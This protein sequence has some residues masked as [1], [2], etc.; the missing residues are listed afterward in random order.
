MTSDG[1]RSAVI[2]LKAIA[3]LRATL[4]EAAS[5]AA[6]KADIERILEATSQ[7]AFVAILGEDYFKIVN[8][9]ADNKGGMIS[10]DEDMVLKGIIKPS[11]LAKKS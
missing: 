6:S 5:G 3:V 9:W 11:A 1:D 4:Y 8:L 7:T 2:F 10:H